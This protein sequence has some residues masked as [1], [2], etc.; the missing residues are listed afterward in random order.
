[1]NAQDVVDAINGALAFVEAN[2]GTATAS[3]A[4]VGGLVHW[5]RGLPGTQRRKARREARM[6]RR[7]G[8]G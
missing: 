4:L 8:E 3:V 2:K 6:A 5:F 1:M 7:R